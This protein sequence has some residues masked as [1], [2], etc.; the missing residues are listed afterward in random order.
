MTKAA[1]QDYI[2]EQVE[3]DA[4]T[5]NERR[6][7]RQLLED[8]PVPGTFPTYGDLQIDALGNLW[9]QDFLAPG[10]DTPRWTIFSSDGHVLG[11]ISTPPRTRVLEIGGDYLL[12]RYVDEID[13]EFVRLYALECPSL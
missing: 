2:D 11:R 9:A 6:S 7:L 13:V 1:V 8:L 4:D 3:E 10:E 12:T 5:E